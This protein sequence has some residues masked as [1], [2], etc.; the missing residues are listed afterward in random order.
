[1][2]RC[3]VRR[4]VL[5]AVG[6]LL[7][8]FAAGAFPAQIAVA[9]APDVSIKS[10]TQWPMPVDP[11]EEHL[12][13]EV[14]NSGGPAGLIRIDLSLKDTFGV[15]IGQPRSTYVKA[16]VLGT[17]ERAPFE[18]VLFPP[19]AGYDHYVATV[20]SVAGTIASPA[21]AFTFALDDCPSMDP[22]LTACQQQ[23]PQAG[24]TG[25]VRNDTGA[26][27]DN[28][29]A[30]FTFLDNAGTPNA[31]A[32][33][34]VRVYN[35]QGGL[36]LN[37]GDTGTFAV[38]RNGEP[39]FTTFRMLAEPDYPLDVNPESV[40]FG[41]QLVHTTSGGVEITLF[42]N[43]P[44]TIA[45]SST[46]VVNV[47]SED[48]EF[49]PATTC[50]NV[51]AGASCRFSV[52]FT[53]S[54]M[55]NRSANLVLTEAAAGSPHTIPLS[56][57]GVAPVMS[58]D[59]TSAAGLSFADTKV[60]N[61]SQSSEKV[62]ND[63]TAPMAIT[64]VTASNDFAAASQCPSSLDPT[65]SCLINVTFAPTSGGSRAGTLTITDSAD[66]SPHTVPLSGVGIGPGVSFDHT[67]VAFG[68]VN[69]GD[70]PTIAVL[71]TNSGNAD[72]K[73][74][75]ITVPAAV[76][77]ND[78]CPRNPLVIAQG[79]SCTINVK[80]A[81]N[82]PG[83]FNGNLTVTDNVGNSPQT[84]PVSG[85][86][87]SPASVNPTSLNFDARQLHS[88]SPAKTV[89]LTNTGTSN[90]TITG[91]GITGPFNET[92]DCVSPLAGK[93]HCTFSVTFTPVQGGNAAG[94]LSVTAGGKTLVVP[95][96]GTGVSAN[97]ESLGGL[98]PSYP[99][100]SSWGT[101][102]MD[103]FVRGTDRALWHRSFDGNNWSNWESLGGLL[104]SDP[105][106]VSWGPNHIDVFV[107]GTD[108]RLWQ[109]TLDNGTWSNWQPLGG[110]IGSAPS[111]SSGTVGH[112]DV[113]VK[114]TDGNMWQKTFDIGTG[115][116]NWQPLGGPIGSR[117]SAVSSGAGHIDVFAKGTDG[118]MWQKT[119]ANGSW[120]NWQPLGG[121]IGSTP[122]AVS[123]GSGRLAV[124]V[125]GTDG[126]L[127]ARLF[128]GSWANWT[129]A[130]AGGGVLGSEPA[131]VA[132][133]GGVVDVFIRGT[134]GA[135]WHVALG[136]L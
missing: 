86:A 60:G 22:T 10:A 89:T 75:S 123:L 62:T 132:R 67:S 96:T 35:A 131:A 34:T 32:Q 65:K 71:L 57:R 84:L 56:G 3:A 88:T 50:A 33:D 82:A 66:G 111:A 135:V 103:L 113:F 20:G 43:G 59:P 83:S 77:K 36:S 100:V 125:R 102:R 116:G 26:A 2:L 92:D 54:Q 73:I 124:F 19:P 63:G 118:N 64:N 98:I 25:T 53:P 1:V 104:G 127:W 6:A 120:G 129:D 110:P 9:A 29:W 94:N 16:Q 14:L 114:G 87:V 69:V 51:A 76:T 30:I 40:A 85:T 133:T 74:Q 95:L 11:K 39:A 58:L 28:V 4:P 48:G 24:F 107:K 37:A 42:N 68:T 41:D 112:I 45:I 117:P 97:W 115:W 31:I 55:G 81:P 47:T 128:N 80:Y 72:L 79:L 119:F 18:E 134:D 5:L 49:S 99:T 108:G 52:T 91:I 38:D 122:S 21:H 46:T 15:S 27:V 121:P 70:S 106:A 90:I 61:T 136:N 101:S 23:V 44:R 17:N 7:L 126:R 78:N 109:K 130:F 105:S 12:V 93:A 8:P 13:G